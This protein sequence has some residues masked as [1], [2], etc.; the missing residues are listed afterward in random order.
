[1]SVL[2][3]IMLLFVVLCAVVSIRA[4]QSMVELFKVMPD[5]LMPT[6]T[7]NN[8]LD[9]IDFLDAKMKANATN[10][11]DGITEMTYMSADSLSVQI[12]P[13]ERVDLY[14]V[15]TTQQYDS[16]YQVVCFKSVYQLASTK[17]E[18]I[19]CKFYS[20]GWKPLSQPSLVAPVQSTS[21][22]LRQDGE[23]FKENSTEPV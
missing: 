12:S 16:C 8:R 1:M 20:I 21:T 23:V 2:K 17:E 7:K 18:E 22:I 14:L 4:Q 3:R 9:L 6:L 13:V 15:A 11:L 5:S 10:R 19:A